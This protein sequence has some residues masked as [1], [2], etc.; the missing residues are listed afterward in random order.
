MGTFN[1]GL[2]VALDE[3]PLEVGFDSAA[4]ALKGFTLGES[5]EGFD[6]VVEVSVRLLEGGLD[7]HLLL[8]KLNIL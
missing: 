3:L 6:V 2:L 1:S 5:W 8:H 4:L 7:L